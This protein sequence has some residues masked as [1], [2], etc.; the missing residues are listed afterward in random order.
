MT[1]ARW[2][3][4]VTPPDAA[5]TA[6]LPD[7]AALCVRAARAA[8]DAAPPVTGRGELSIALA[9]DALSRRLNRDYRDRDA[10][11]N[12]LSFPGAGPRGGEPPLVGDIVLALATIRDEAADQGKSLADH[13]SHLVVHGVLHISGYDHYMEDDATVMEQLETRVLASIG[14]ADPYAARGTLPSHAAH[15]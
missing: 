11:T 14:V 1:T 10:P 8:L 6:A 5:W 7:A 4:M 2:D 13:V 12:V 15:A 3:I 9:D